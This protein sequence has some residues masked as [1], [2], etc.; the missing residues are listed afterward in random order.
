MHALMVWIFHFAILVLKCCFTHFLMRR[1]L[2][3]LPSSLFGFLP[4]PRSFIRPSHNL[5]DLNEDKKDLWSL[6]FVFCFAENKMKFH[7]P[8]CHILHIFY[9]FSGQTSLSSYK[10]SHLTS[11]HS[12]FLR[13]HREDSETYCQYIQCKKKMNLFFFWEK[14][15]SL[16]FYQRQCADGALRIGD[17]ETFCALCLLHKQMASDW[18]GLLPYQICC[19]LPS[20]MLYL[21]ELLTT[22]VVPF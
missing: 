4:P 5:N 11:I 21:L 22:R 8:N 7:V 16:C 20:Q 9:Y 1:L 3:S 10:G 18:V 14:N 15:Y 13:S 6:Q 2:C 12:R 17:L 19:V